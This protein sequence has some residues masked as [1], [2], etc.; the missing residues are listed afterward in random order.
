M[1]KVRTKRGS[2]SL[3]VRKL[4]DDHRIV[5]QNYSPQLSAV[6]RGR[7]RDRE[8]EGVEK[9]TR[10]KKEAKDTS[11]IRIPHQQ[12]LVTKGKERE[13]ERVVAKRD[14]DR[15]T[16]RKFFSSVL[17]VLVTCRT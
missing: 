6:E 1:N 17:F 9:I 15:Q 2:L 13:R 14:R 7:G 8:R 5:V 16:E 12:P 3:F 11:L 4:E 10:G